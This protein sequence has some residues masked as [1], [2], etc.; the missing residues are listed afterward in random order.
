MSTL[1]VLHVDAARE[2]R[3]GQSQVRLLA[4]EL[5]DR[6]GV[7]QT[8]AAGA[9]SRL[10]REGE[11]AGVAVRQLPWDA[12]LDPRAVAGIAAEADRFD[13]VHAHSAHALQACVL[14]LAVAGGPAGLVAARR[15]LRPVSP[16]TAWRRADLLLAVSGAVRESLLG[17]GLAP[18]RVRVVPDGVAIPSSASAAP[19]RLREAAGADAG[20]TLVGAVGA[21]GP[22]KDHR[23]LV[24]AAARVAE[25]RPDV[26]FVVAGEGPLRD[27]LEAEVR[28][29][30]LEGRFAL[31]GHVADVG[32]S[33]G[34]LDLFVM[35]S[36][37]EGLGTAALEAMA[38]GVPTLVTRAGG[39]VDVAGDALPTVPPEDPGALAAEIARLLDDPEARRA[40]GPAGRRRVEE[41]FTASRTAEATL[42]AYRAV[43][44]SRRRRRE[45]VRRMERIGRLRRA[46]PPEA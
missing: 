26:R 20:A 27:R 8:L 17:A 24:R 3:G 46:R 30:G 14:A 23:T 33:L 21:L 29:R 6:P 41:R 2:W 15:S 40:L 12:A 39:L 1:R 22:E 34:D 28:E 44:G 16:A 43:A 31:P 10:A 18:S 42:A 7:R 11:A 25:G 13:V 19:G 4:A 35:C 9:G 37:E 32:R 5:A 36:R 45:H 38:A